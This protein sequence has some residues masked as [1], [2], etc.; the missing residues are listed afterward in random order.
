MEAITD[1]PSYTVP[2][3]VGQLEV[4]INITGGQLAPDDECR[5]AVVTADGSATGV[6]WAF[7][8]NTSY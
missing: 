1:Q 4:W 3:D 2:E 7:V 6:S 5:I 8:I